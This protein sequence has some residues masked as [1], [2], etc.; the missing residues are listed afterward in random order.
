MRIHSLRMIVTSDL[1][2]KI[3]AAQVEALKEENWKSERITSY[4]PHFEDDSLWI[5]TRQGRIYIPFQSHV[6]E[7]LLEE[8]HKSKYS[9]HLGATNMYLDLKR[10]YWWPVGEDNDGFCD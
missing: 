10:N 9:I 4:I 8:A 3:K 5:K 7:L 1:F 2:D 6:K